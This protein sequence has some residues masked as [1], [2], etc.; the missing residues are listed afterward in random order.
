MLRS[1]TPALAGVLSLLGAQ[2]P[3]TLMPPSQEN[4]KG[5]WES[6]ELFRIHEELFAR[7]GFSWNDYRRFPDDWMSG[8][9]AESFFTGIVETLHSELQGAKVD[10]TQKTGHLWRCCPD[11]KHLLYTKKNH[12]T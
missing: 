1:G 6:N 8:P 4:E 9:E 5:Y 10:Y 12:R 3:K 2:P 7:V 11:A